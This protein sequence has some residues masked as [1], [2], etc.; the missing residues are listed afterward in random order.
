MTY[1]DLKRGGKRIASERERKRGRVNG[2][3]RKGKQTETEKTKGNEH[4][5]VSRLLFP[6]FFPSN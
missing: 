4:I 6:S 2:E 3:R 1:I 5:D